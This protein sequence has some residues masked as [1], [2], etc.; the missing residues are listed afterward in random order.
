[1]TPL[2]FGIAASVLWALAAFVLA[3]GTA[4]LTTMAD[5]VAL[6]LVGVLPPAVLWFWWRAP[7]ETMSETIH[8]IRDNRQASGRRD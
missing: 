2:R 5:R 3:A 1:M 8:R 7:S 6:M 4:H